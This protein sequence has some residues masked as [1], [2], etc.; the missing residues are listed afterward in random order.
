MS[1]KKNKLERWVTEQLLPVDKKARPTRG[2]G[3]G[4]EIGDNSNDYLF[5]ECKEKHT[6]SN[7]IMERAI[8][9]KHLNSLPIL[10]KKIP[11]YVT[12]NKERDKFVILN[13]TDF[14]NII[15]KLKKNG[16]L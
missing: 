10:T 12:E 16:D 14:F 6:K 13:A 9:Y 15:K 7:I 4:N 3:C 11:I 2:S 5:V 8:W 1:D